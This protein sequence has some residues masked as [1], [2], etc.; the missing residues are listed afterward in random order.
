MR[1]LAGTKVPSK[2]NFALSLSHF[3]DWL[4]SRRRSDG[5]T[6]HP[7]LRR[8]DSIALSPAG[9]IISPCEAQPQLIGAIRP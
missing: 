8:R 7:S 6:V 2:F 4:K 5:R 1:Q 9:I 3:T